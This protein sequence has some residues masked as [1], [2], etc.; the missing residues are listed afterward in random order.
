MPDRSALQQAL[1][2]AE[3]QYTPRPD[4]VPGDLRMSW[5]IAILLFALLHSR[6]KKS[7]F[8]KLQFLAHAVRLVDPSQ[9]KSPAGDSL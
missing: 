3:F 6:G 9:H 2:N 5:G 1:R 8:Q 7:N 4:P